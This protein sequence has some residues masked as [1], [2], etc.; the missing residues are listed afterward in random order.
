MSFIALM[1]VVPMMI[2]STVTKD[3]IL[4]GVPTLGNEAPQSSG[5]VTNAFVY[6]TTDQNPFEIR[7]HLAIVLSSLGIAR[8]GVYHRRTNSTRTRARPN[9]RLP[10]RWRPPRVAMVEPEHRSNRFGYTATRKKRGTGRSTTR[11]SHADG[12]CCATNLA[13]T[14]IGRSTNYQTIIGRLNQKHTTAPEQRFSIAAYI[15]RHESRD[16]HQRQHSERQHER[17][18]K[19]ITLPRKRS[20]QYSLLFWARTDPGRFIRS[21]IRMASCAR[22]GAGIGIR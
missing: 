10:I 22:R 8:F 16:L 19:P 13:T 14:I 12:A 17:V 7:S 21:T 6:R 15:P 3:P 11:D 1:T 18:W 20:S 2:E 5:G 9:T 4:R